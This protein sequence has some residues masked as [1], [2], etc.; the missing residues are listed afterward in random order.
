M[1]FGPCR[2][3]NDAQL[4]NLSSSREPHGNRDGSALP[5]LYRWTVGGG[6]GRTVRSV[7]VVRLEGR[8]ERRVSDE[9]GRLKER[10]PSL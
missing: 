4:R 2:M 8:G 1:Y 6:I 10:L 9:G 5:R 3:V 7:D